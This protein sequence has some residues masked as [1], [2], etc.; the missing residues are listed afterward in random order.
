MNSTPESIAGAVDGR[1]V[2]DATEV[3]T[4]LQSP[5]DQIL[6]DPVGPFI[7]LL[8]AIAFLPVWIDFFTPNTKPK[9]K[10]SKG[11]SNGKSRT[12]TIQFPGDTDHSGN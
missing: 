7:L 2:Q 9:T 6:G 4:M 3:Q 12:I 8:L 1:I 5:R 11:K 10:S